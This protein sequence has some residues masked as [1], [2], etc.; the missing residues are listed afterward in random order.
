M[1]AGT[2]RS[3]PWIWMAQFLV[4]SV[5]IGFLK[6]TG[7]IDATTAFILFVAATGL[8]VSYAFSLAR[9]RGPGAPG[10][11]I[12]RYTKGIA[13]T[14]LLYVFGLGIAITLDK[15]MELEGAAAFLVALM[16]VLPIL[17]MIW[18]MG[19]YL[20]EEQDEYLR[21][22]AIIASLVGLAL[23]L[24]FGSFW[25]FLE[26]FGLVPHAAGWWAVPVWAIGMGLGQCW[27]ALRDRAGGEE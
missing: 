17:G 9:K 12:V 1:S 25:G 16:P 11:A 8:V 15:R 21:H 19:R 5:V 14:S 10:A 27:M 13:I 7:A 22:K 20:V 6:V 23:V 4:A 24:G 18:V 2:R 26:Q 3:R